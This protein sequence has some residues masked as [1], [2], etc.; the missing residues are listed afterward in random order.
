MSSYLVT[1]YKSRHHGPVMLHDFEINLSLPQRLSHFNCFLSNQRI[2]VHFNLQKQKP[3]KS[4]YRCISPHWPFTGCTKLTFFIREIKMPTLSNG[5]LI[6]WNARNLRVVF[7]IAFNV[8]LTL[9]F[10]GSVELQC[11]FQNPITVNLHRN[12]QNK[13]LV[14]DIKDSLVALS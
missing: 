10:G 1:W 4:I 9:I 7:F 3:I 12:S 2:V 14:C 6:V 13:S 11:V 8:T 5:H